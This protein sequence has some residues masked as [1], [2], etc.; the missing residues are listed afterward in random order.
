MK[1]SYIW[2]LPTRVFHWLF[3]LF[4]LLAFLSA[5]EDRWLDY[6]AIV[7]YAILIL[8]VFRIIWGVIGPKY[9]LFKDFPIGKSNVKEFL[10]NIFE[11]KQKYIGHNPLA[12]Y[13]MISMFI[14]AIL[15]IITGILAF[16]IQEGKG[17]LSFLN[18][19]LFKKMELFKEIH[20]VLTSL[21]IALII[22][23]LAGILSD[24]LLHKKHETLN[25]IISGYKVTQEDKSIK[26]NIYQKIFSIL[27]FLFFVGFL[28]FNFYKPDNILITS[29]YEQ[30]DYNVQNELFVSE[31]ASCHT[32]YPSQSFT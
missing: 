22:A 26:L 16:G 28:V 14:V 15:I 2:S 13:V 12:S 8:L 31:C 19:S 27:M 7:G 30:I 3:V 20:E 17:I 9:S 4:I 32:L 24:R 18:T 1:K 6:H 5:Q 10:N 25:S 11:S 21:F 29:K 23:H